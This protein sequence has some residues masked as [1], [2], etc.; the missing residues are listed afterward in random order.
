MNQ[1]RINKCVYCLKSTEVFSKNHSKKKSPSNSDKMMLQALWNSTIQEHDI[2][3]QQLEAEYKKHIDDLLDK[4]QTV[5]RQIQRYLCLLFI[6]LLYHFNITYHIITFK[7]V[8]TGKC[9]R[10]YYKSNRQHIYCQVNQA[11]AIRGYLITT[12][13]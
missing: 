10:N 5:H 2:L 8:T 12:Q 4:K 13:L 3:V 11:I 9:I 7:Y 1:K 6:V